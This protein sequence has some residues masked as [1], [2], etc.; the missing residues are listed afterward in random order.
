MFSPVFMLNTPQIVAD[1]RYKRV[2]MYINFKR[3]RLFPWNYI[4]QKFFEYQ[5]LTNM[6]FCVY[7]II[8][9]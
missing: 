7:N 4:I 8:T 1:Y 3:R 5:S 2:N 6:I 9:V